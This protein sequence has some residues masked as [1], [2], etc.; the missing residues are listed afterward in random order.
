ME[1]LVEAHVASLG[2]DSAATQPA[3]RKIVGCD[4]SALGPVSP[5]SL[6]SHLNDNT[7]R[8][9]RNRRHAVKH[10][11]RCAALVLLTLAAQAASAQTQGVSKTEIVLGTSQDLSGPLA[12]FG[13]DQLNGML[14]RIA[15]INEQGGVH[16]RKLRLLA[17]D[18]GYD[19]KKAVLAAQK[20]VSQDKIFLMVGSIGTPTNL[21]AMPVLFAK[22]IIN[23]MPTSNAREM[24]D[25][26]TKLKW[27]FGPPS[28]EA[29]RQTV[30]PLFREKKATKAC[31]L[32]QDD[33]SGL[34]VVRGAEAGLK[35][36][37]VEIA[38]RTTFKRGATEFSSQVAR[39]KSANCDFVILGTVIRETVGTLLEMRKL[40]YNP[41]VIGNMASYTALI[42]KL[43]GKAMDGFYA[44]YFA[45][46][47]YLD[48]ASSAVRFWARKYQTMFNAEP[49]VVSVIG[50]AIA[51]RLVAVLQKTGPNLTTETFARSMESMTIPA[52]IF[53]IP[54]MRFS[55]AM[56]LGTTQVYLAQIQEGRWKKVAVPP[57]KAP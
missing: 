30:P 33:E 1:A 49:S 57:A 48:D 25:P 3:A 20:L 51:D 11:I 8:S 39:L 42:P 4:D 32:Y 15:E 18:H 31:T 23:F 41:A 9:S 38:E 50:Y 53:G 14:L 5:Q 2:R 24:Y 40:D 16:G 29:S 56:H 36:I 45:P 37:G 7:R 10:F 44:P 13:K 54:E 28:Y 19:P 12:P 43:G 17:E 21:A 22:N 52:D 27:A 26:P 6:R 34:E 55:S 47:P 46:H 35:E